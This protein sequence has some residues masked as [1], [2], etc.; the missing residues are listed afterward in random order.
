MDHIMRPTT[1]A[2]PALAALRM[3]IPRI[4]YCDAF[5]F[6]A[7]SYRT[8]ELLPSMGQ[9][10]RLPYASTAYPDSASALDPSEGALLAGIRCWVAGYRERGDPLPDLCQEMDAAGVHDA[11]F[12]VDQLMAIFTHAARRPMEV[13]CPGC[14]ALSDDEKQLLSAA[15]LAQAGECKMAERTLRT[16]LLSAQGAEFA[17]GP[18]H[19]LAE[20]FAEAKLFFRRRRPPLNADDS[21]APQ[22]S[23][24]IH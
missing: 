5:A 13:H 17:L 9:I 7:P 15:S 16:T 8:S 22:S 23:I 24:D 11:A 2:V 4:S 6:T 21:T 10:I 3:P 14:P 1:G 19:G 12:S 18:L 20:L